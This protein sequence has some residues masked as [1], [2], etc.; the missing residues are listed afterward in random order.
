MTVAADIS[1]PSIPASA[2]IGGWLRLALLLVIAGLFVASLWVF[3]AGQ[4]FLSDAHRRNMHALS[5]AANGLQYWPDSIRGLAVSQFVSANVHSA[6]PAQALEGWRLA[7]TMR[8]P[9]LGTF[10]ILYAFA[11]KG[12]KGQ[13]GGPYAAGCEDLQ[14]NIE[15]TEEGALPFIESRAV[16]EGAAVK[17]FGSV[18]LAQARL[19]DFTDLHESIDPH[20]DMVAV[21]QK[22]HLRPPG[23]AAGV[24][25]CFGAEAATRNLVSFGET[26]SYFSNMLIIDGNKRVVQQVG[27]EPLPVEGLD[28]LRQSDDL[29]TPAKL[30][31]AISGQSTPPKPK[32]APALADAL[33]PITLQIA[34][35]AY[36][37]YVR[38]FHLPGGLRGCDKVGQQSAVALDPAVRLRSTCYLVGLVPRAKL[39]ADAARATP[40]VMITFSLAIA[41]IASIFPIVRLL[42]IG[43]NESLS[44]YNLALIVGGAIVSLSFVSLAVLTW[45]DIAFERSRMLI[46]AEASAQMV[47]R[48]ASNELSEIIDAALEHRG[49]RDHDGIDRRHAAAP[50][51]AVQV[52]PEPIG[53]VSNG[54]VSRQAVE[55]LESITHIAANGRPT[56]CGVPSVYTHAFGTNRFE[57]PGRS[58]FKRFSAGQFSGSFPF[59]ETERARAGTPLGYVVDQVRD[60]TDGVN[61]AIV[62]L[63]AIEPDHATPADVPKDAS[64]PCW[65][66][67]YLAT[68]VIGALLA[69]VLPSGMEMAVVDATDP[70][71]PVKFH[72]RPERIGV[73]QMAHELGSRPL[74]QLRE[75]IG[76]S[77]TSGAA[78]SGNYLFNS[79]ADGARRQFVARRIPHTPWVV[80]LSYSFADVDRLPVIRTARAIVSG[81]TLGLA[82]LVLWWVSAII[83]P[84]IARN[85]WPHEKVMSGTAIDKPSMTYA[86]VTLIIGG[87]IALEVVTLSLPGLYLIGA[88]AV[89]TTAAVAVLYLQS[90][91]TP[92]LA[93]TLSSVNER[94]FTRLSLA[95]LCCV[96]VIPTIAIWRDASIYTDAEERVSR[97]IAFGG[98]DGALVRH[99]RALDDIA[100]S[101]FPTD[102]AKRE[103]APAFFCDRHVFVGA[104]PKRC[105]DHRLVPAPAEESF[106]GFW[107]SPRIEHSFPEGLAGSFPDCAP[108]PGVPVPSGDDFCVPYQRGDW[109]MGYQ[110]DSHSTAS[111]LRNTRGSTLLLISL[112]ILIVGF[113][114]WR[115]LR[116]TLRAL[117]GF[118]AA[119]GID[120]RSPALVGAGFPLRDAVDGATMR[121]DERSLPGT[122]DAD[123]AFRCLILETLPLPAHVLSGTIGADAQPRVIMAMTNHL[124]TSDAL[125]IVFEW[126]ERVAAPSRVEA[127]EYL[128]RLLAPYYQSIWDSLTVAERIG[129]HHLAR[130]RVV[131][132]GRAAAVVGSLLRRG[133][134]VLDPSPRL[135]NESFAA[136]VRQAAQ[137]STIQSWARGEGL[138]AWSSSRLPLLIG[139]PGLLLSFALILFWADMDVASIM[140]IFVTGIPALFG[141]WQKLKP[142][143]SLI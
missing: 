134:I 107:F 63:E 42:L 105:L 29:L 5:V 91:S 135:M 84:P 85:L 115:L 139:I 106:Y 78:A 41:L 96:S 2:G 138:S 66:A 122:Y 1:N 141:L 31:S 110:S 136:F 46:E 54:R 133:L 17:V 83:Y 8:N 131:N 108:V 62:M 32:D 13:P 30:T 130:Q 36:V 77:A 87:L 14:T 7:T 6:S 90:H 20:E 103:D 16:G 3:R 126:A 74:R 137:E 88:I 50:E 12:M 55:G 38:P 142:A 4:L 18:P 58:Y 101:W 98:P 9:D 10:D 95:F 102:G 28:Q 113:A 34:G 80:L 56:G 43:P 49:P 117:F 128:R 70:T 89:L 121:L 99:R 25:L 75:W 111:R 94:A 72:S 140:P 51:M 44:R 59:P 73:E 71:L 124:S 97:A 15:K 82:L 143:K 125:N 68:G 61:K 52:I 39:W 81:L 76:Y 123:R 116:A 119:L 118:G 112:T 22:A 21:F 53:A 100:E 132:V 26:R 19:L 86:T 69:P 45:A 120:A 57:V 48:Q 60:Q 11:G 93:G 92:R 47:A 64:S 104:G 79:T 109:V 40:L 127:I 23:S 65:T 114:T 33:S 27:E 67:G 35:R 129:L 37:A 24:T